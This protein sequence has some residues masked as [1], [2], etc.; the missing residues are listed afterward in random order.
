MMS[1]EPWGQGSLEPK[2]EEPEEALV[3]TDEEGRVLEVNRA[4]VRLFGLTLADTQ[5]EPV[6]DLIFPPRLR[7]AY[8]ARRRQALSGGPFSGASRTGDFSGLLR[9]GGEFSIEL[10]IAQTGE[11]PP[12]VAT[13][14]RAIT[15]ADMGATS[16]SDRRSALAGRMEQ[17]AGFGSWEC[18]P[19]T[20]ELFWSENLFR[21]C[22]LEPDEIIPTAEYLISHAHPRDRQRVQRAV[23]RLRGTGRLLPLRYRYVLPDG[24]VR[25]MLAT[26]TLIAE[27]PGLPPHTLGFL[28]DITA[29]YA[30]EQEIAAHFAVSDALADWRSLD[31]GA[32]RLLRDLGEALDFELGVLWVPQENALVAQVIWLARTLDAP[33]L[34]AS[35]REVRLNEG[36][37][38][39][40]SAWAARE[41]VVVTSLAQNARYVLRQ[42]VSEAGLH[43]ALAMPVPFGDDVLAVL[44]FAS[45]DEVKLTDRLVRSLVGIGYE[46]GHFFARRRGEF[47]LPLLTRRELE[48]LQLATAG[49][50][51]GEIADKLDVRESTIKTH[52]EHIY[53]KLGVHDRSAAVA[54]AIRQGL[55]G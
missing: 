41:P 3:I 24:S 2:S 16:M 10:S 50:S 39:A 15:G 49:F 44:G 17:L 13:R 1:R 46:I 28:R 36:V 22:G 14:I 23:D 5:D 34:D 12:R 30:A 20:G 19:A 52:F 42:L 6:G 37:G 27:A 26:M 21:L 7:A 29:E 45:Q 43:G 51:G 25:R 18:V 55:I 54:E 38:L 40:G 9:D 35:L 47:E 53:R 33:N 11:D 32:W 8:R 4:F 31:S 48:V